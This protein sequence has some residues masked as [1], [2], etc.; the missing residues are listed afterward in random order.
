VRCPLWQTHIFNSWASFLGVV[1]GFSPLPIGRH[2]Q[3]A[4]TRAPLFILLQEQSSEQADSRF[5]G[6]K[7]ADDALAATD[8]FVETFLPIGRPQSRT[9]GAG[10][11]QYRRCVVKA[12][13]QR[14][15]GCESQVLI[16][17]NDLGKQ[18]AGGRQLAGIPRLDQRIQRL[19]QLGDGRLG[20]A[21]ATELFR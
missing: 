7:D 8:L 18:C 6:G 10:Q 2:V 20:E 11:G 17:V 3:V 15:H 4:L 9:V 5:A 12:A 21:R 16:V 1:P 19:A 14:G 13:F